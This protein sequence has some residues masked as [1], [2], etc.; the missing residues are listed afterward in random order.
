MIE[1]T[2]LLF[3]SFPPDNPFLKIVDP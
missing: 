2:K 1:Q 3:E